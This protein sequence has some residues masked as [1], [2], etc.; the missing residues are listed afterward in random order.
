MKKCFLSIFLVSISM[1]A[2]ASPTDEISHL[3]KYVESTDCTYER[4]GD[5]YS[6][7]EAMKH[8]TRKYQY[9]SED[10]ETAEDFIKYSA[11][12]SKMSGKYYM[13][14]CADQKPVKSSDWLLAE[15]KRYR[16]IRG[17]SN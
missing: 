6:G 16:A 9:F 2:F 8:I 5:S 7:V 1:W 11:T 12:K 15:L 13:V 4:N 10:I 14:Y 17:G 3:L